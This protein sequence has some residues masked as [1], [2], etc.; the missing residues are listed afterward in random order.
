M[1]ILK[2]LDCR[3]KANLNDDI[4]NLL[5]RL[6]LDIGE[7]GKDR[8]FGEGFVTLKNIGNIGE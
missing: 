6:T 3:S 4:Y 8:V 2:D 5:K 1:Q 7:K